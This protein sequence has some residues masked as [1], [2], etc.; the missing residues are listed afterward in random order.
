MIEV[1][2][3]IGERKLTQAEAAKLLGVTQPRGSAISFTEGLIFLA[4]IPW[5]ACLPVPGSTSM[6][7]S[8]QPAK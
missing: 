4:S 8:P 6:L 5:W 2:Q 3:L 7:S 1:R